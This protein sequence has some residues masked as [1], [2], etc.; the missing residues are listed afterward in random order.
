MASGEDNAAAAFELKVLPVL[1]SSGLARLR[2]H[3]TFGFAH[4]PR[5]T[6]Y[7]TVTNGS[8]QPLLWQKPVDVATVCADETLGTGLHPLEIEKRSNGSVELR[9]T[10]PELI[11][12]ADLAP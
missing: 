10:V 7:A 4:R 11:M 2:L 12:L 8:L 6:T 3:V 1:F 5:R 9:T